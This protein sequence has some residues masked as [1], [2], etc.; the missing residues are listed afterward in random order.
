MHRLSNFIKDALPDKGRSFEL[1]KF[2]DVPT[3]VP[4]GI[5][6][7][8]RRQQ[9]LE[10]RRRPRRRQTFPEAVKE[11]RRDVVEALQGRMVT[12]EEKK[13]HG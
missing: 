10:S 5:Q 2:L 3:T 1:N 6:G 11:V 8:L 13:N 12:I 7:Y 4:T 9:L